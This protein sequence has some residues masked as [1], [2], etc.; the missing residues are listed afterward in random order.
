LSIINVTCAEVD[1][2]LQAYLA[3]PVAHHDAGVLEVDE[4]LLLQRL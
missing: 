4:V 3:A 2:L 1:G